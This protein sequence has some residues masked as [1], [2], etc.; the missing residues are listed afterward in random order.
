VDPAQLTPA[1]RAVVRELDPVVPVFETMTLDAVRVRSTWD[2]RLFSSMFLIFGLVALFLASMGLYAVMSYSVT[3]RTHEIGVRVALGAQVRDVLTLVVG[4]GARLAGVG[5]GV[6]LALAFGV[7]RLLRGML[8]G[9]SASDPLSFVG[10]AALLTIVAV[11]ASYLPA[12]RAARVDPM[13]ALR[14]E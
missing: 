3:Q 1:V 12:R 9:I 10:I 6:G 8:F 13:A 7:T 2:S 11:V 5:V 14:S 4:G